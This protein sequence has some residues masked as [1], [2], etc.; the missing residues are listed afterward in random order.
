MTPDERFDFL[1]RCLRDA[2]RTGRAPNEYGHRLRNQIRKTLGLPLKPPID[3][4]AEV[5]SASTAG[6]IA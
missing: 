6:G 4:T 2:E 1:Y 3:L 5:E